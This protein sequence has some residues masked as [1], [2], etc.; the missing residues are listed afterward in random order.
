MASILFSIQMMHFLSKFNI[1]ASTLLRR[2][3]LE[4]TESCFPFTPRVPGATVLS[5]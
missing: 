5:S 4:I 1:S 2:R 3:V